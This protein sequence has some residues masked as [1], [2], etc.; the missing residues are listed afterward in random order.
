MLDRFS[1]VDDDHAEGWLKVRSDNLLVENGAFTEP[2]LI[3]HIAQTAAARLGYICLKEG[4]AVP[5]GYIGSIEHIHIFSLPKI[6]EEIKTEVY[7]K[8]QIFN[9]TVVEGKVR[10]GDKLVAQ[11]EMKIFIS[12]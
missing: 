12:N 2:G 5:L 10:T 4:K 1:F 8:N 6:N 9:V 7:I 11:C 3:E